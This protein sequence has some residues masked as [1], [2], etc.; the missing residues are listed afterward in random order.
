M[1]QM[2]ITSCSREGSTLERNR[3]QVL[4]FQFNIKTKKSIFYTIVLDLLFVRCQLQKYVYL[5][6]TKKNSK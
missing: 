2:E 3:I 1:H 5:F 4:L 6:Q